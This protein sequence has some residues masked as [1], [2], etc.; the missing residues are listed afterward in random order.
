MKNIRKEIQEALLS[1]DCDFMIKIDLKDKSSIIA[2]IENCSFKELDQKTFEVLPRVER[3][4]ELPIYIHQISNFI[5]FDS[6]VNKDEWADYRLKIY[7]LE[8]SNRIL[9][10][11]FNTQ[12]LIEI[13]KNRKQEYESF[14][15]WNSFKKEKTTY[16]LDK[17]KITQNPDLYCQVKSEY[18]CSL[19]E[20]LERDSEILYK[21]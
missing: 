14:H 6:K 7:D 15:S 10:K 4:G 19:R 11:S 21:I 20:L 17:N 12:D 8:N 9:F 3:K 2:K 1:N 13:Y 18:S 16:F 5:V